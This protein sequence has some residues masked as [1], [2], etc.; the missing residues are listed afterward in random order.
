MILRFDSDELLTWLSQTIVVII[1]R[2]PFLC[3]ISQPVI[4]MSKPV[5]VKSRRIRIS[6]S[7]RRTFQLRT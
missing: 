7:S 2:L 5:V 6:E 4:S 3:S 1:A